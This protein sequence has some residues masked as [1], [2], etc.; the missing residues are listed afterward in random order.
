M[1]QSEWFRLLSRRPAALVSG[2][3]LLAALL[4]ACNVWSAPRFTVWVSVKAPSVTVTRNG[5]RG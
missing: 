5:P 1:D 4:V 2:A 3:V